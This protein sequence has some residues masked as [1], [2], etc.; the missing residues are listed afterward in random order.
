MSKR[1]AADLLIVRGRARKFRERMGIVTANN[2]FIQGM[3]TNIRFLGSV[4]NDAR[5]SSVERRRGTG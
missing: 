2:E 1:A 5:S 3:M 4:A